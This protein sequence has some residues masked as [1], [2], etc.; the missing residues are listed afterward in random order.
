MNRREFARSVV[1]A[2]AALSAACRDKSSSQ[3]GEAGDS[4]LWD[5]VR[6]ALKAIEASPDHLTAQAKKVVATGDPK[7]IAAWVRDNVTVLPPVAAGA[8]APT[9]QLWGARATMRSGEGSARDRAD[10]L[11]GLLVDAGFKARVITWKRPAAITAEILYR[12]HELAFA[13]DLKLLAPLLE[14]AKRS[15]KLETAPDQE[16]AK[17]CQQLADALLAS[18]DE[19]LLARARPIDAAMPDTLP[20]VEYERDGKRGWAIAYGTWDAVTAADGLGGLAGDADARDVK[21][22]V[23][24]AVNPPARSTID[25]T[26]PHE[27][28]SAKWPVAA[29]AGRQVVIGFVPPRDPK[30]YLMGAADPRKEVKRVAIARLLASEALTAADGAAIAHGPMLGLPE[31]SRARL[32]RARRRS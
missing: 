29:V 28:L 8:Y 20:I 15:P 26:V 2:I 1:G 18:A 10:V 3:H 23:S 21:L 24:V 19:Q 27:V 22:T 32:R 16:V 9:T 5:C 11:A 31:R 7:R 6:D 30:P 17:A 13:P 14:R 25:R 4:A 12:E